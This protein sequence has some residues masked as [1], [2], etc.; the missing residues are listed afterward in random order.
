MRTFREF[1]NSRMQL[2]GK[3]PA[4][5]DIE[6]GRF[7]STYSGDQ[8]KAARDAAIKLYGSLEGF[9]HADDK[10]KWN[11]IWAALHPSEE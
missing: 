7:N 4:N 10:G 3:D 6:L 8:A 2:E 11:R 9:I 1:L 5:Y